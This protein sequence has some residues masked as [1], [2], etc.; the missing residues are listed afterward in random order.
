[1]TGSADQTVGDALNWCRQNFGTSYWYSSSW[2]NICD[3][4]LYGDPSCSEEDCYTAP[5]C[6]ADFSSSS[7]VCSETAASILITVNLDSAPGTGNSASVDYA[8]SDGT[9][10]EG[11]DYTEATGT[12]TFGE[13][14]TAQSFSVTILDEGESEITEALTLTLSNPVGCTLAGVNSPATLTIGDDDCPDSDADGLSD[15]DETNGT[16]GY[17]TDPNDWDSDG[18]GFSDGFEIDRGTD[19]TDGNDFPT[20]VYVDVDAS[21]SNDGSSW[22]DAFSSI[23]SAISAADPGE[24]IWVAEGTYAES[25]TM[26]IETVLYGGFDGTETAFSQ[27]D[28]TEHVAAIDA[29]TAGDGGTAAY[30]V[31]DMEDYARLNGF[32]LTG[33]DAS[34]DPYVDY[35][36]AIG[37][38]IRSI[39]DHDF[40]I[41]N[42][43]IRG[44][45]ASLGG[46]VYC[47]EVTSATISN[48][49][50]R[51]NDAEDYGGGVYYYNSSSPALDQCVIV[52]NSASY[53]G[54]V[55]CD[56]HSSP[57]I[58]DCAVSGNLA[59]QDG[60]FGTGGGVRCEAYSSP[61]LV[62]CILSGNM[63]VEGAGALACA[64][65]SS[66]VL[67]NC[68]ISRNS[69]GGYAGGVYCSSS[70]PILTNCAFEGNDH[71]AIYEYGA[72]SDPSVS[73]GL[74]YGNGNGDWY[75]YDTA[76]TVTGATSINGLAEASGCVDDDPAFQMDSGQG[77]GGTWTSAPSYDSGTDQTTLTDSSAS[78]VPGALSNWLINCDAGQTMHA[79]VCSNT[80]TEV[81]VAGD[82]TAYAGSG[83]TYTLV[84]YHLMSGSAGHKQRH[85]Y[86]SACHRL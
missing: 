33:G 52:S 63:G 7:Y 85:Q 18:D 24:A 28:W 27:R 3:F 21:G 77:M 86:G 67:A 69:A 6:A 84:D 1:M 71:H 40:V 41:A 13:S 9:A 5:P 45:S 20:P 43:I 75:D 35:M 37:G 38:G 46:G 44:N 61:E 32:T 81:A 60:I 36:S 15:L 55:C 42:C 59:D 31:V 16:F 8:T 64:N 72:S 4:N 80:A 29:S 48:C 79:L 39:Q 53:G 51:G 74:F 68:T 12:L 50:V 54:G 56:F 62:N 70:S 66:P 78:L 49:V 83:D 82:V 2:M 34:A 10:S 57:I 17:V 25:I 65:D 73:N 26:S 30:H 19:P 76:S 22:A 58:A 23:A 11:T 14:D 47:E